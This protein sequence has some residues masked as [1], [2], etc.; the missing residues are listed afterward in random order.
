MKRVIILSS[1]VGG[2]WSAA[3]AVADELNAY[4]Q[5][6]CGVDIVDI[7][8]A[9]YA[10]FP[11][12][13][14][15]KLYEPVIRTHPWIW[16]LFWHLTNR[17]VIMR[18]LRWLTTM[19]FDRNELRI[20][21]ADPPSVIVSTIFLLD[22]YRI[23]RDIMSDTECS[24]RYVTIILDPIHVHAGWISSVVDMTM[25]TSLPAEN[26]CKKKYELPLDRLRRMP[27]P[28][29]SG[30][31]RAGDGDKAR[32][33][34]GLDPVKPAVVVLGGAAGAGQLRRIVHELGRVQ[35]PIQ[36]LA[37]CGH[38]Q[39]MRAQ[40][41]AGP[42]APNTTV[43]GFVEDMAGLMSA[44]DAV[45]TKAGPNTVTEAAAL[46]VPVIIAGCLPGQE[47]D[48]PQYYED[49]GVAAWVK[50]LRDL[51][52]TV[53]DVLESRAALPGGR[54]SPDEHSELADTTLSIARE[55][56]RLAQRPASIG[57]PPPTTR[58]YRVPSATPWH[59]SSAS[60]R[61]HCLANL[62]RLVRAGGRRGGTQ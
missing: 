5:G 54:V 52:P 40:L 41:L 36:V 26:T 50:N 42:L 28:V 27:F 62:V 46:Q 45:V 6:T 7:Y 23:I 19:F 16:G 10:R 31:L 21:L 13:A 43:Y 33:A 53:R 39:H 60:S 12:T 49:L 17:M 15:V 8:R 47:R 30:F 55:L 48:N 56:V 18:C 44:A 11:I 59:R 4:T 14:I 3:S 57:S 37:V 38:N 9:P 61:S 32:K 2:H 29:R 35:V 1:H 58:P 34:L 25:V 51:V 20:L 22:Q 24:S